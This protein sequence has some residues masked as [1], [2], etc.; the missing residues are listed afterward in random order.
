[1]SIGERNNV[2][3]YNL[4]LLGFGNVN[5]MLV[6]LLHERKHEL[7]EKHGI[8]CRVTGLATRRLGWIASPGGLDPTVLNEPGTPRWNLLPHL[9][10]PPG[11]VREW[12]R[13]ARADVLFEAT[14]L[15]TQTGQ[16]A[17]DHIRAALE[18]GAHAIT[19][20]KGPVVFAYEELRD[21][22][23][24][25]GRQFLFESTVMDGVPIFSTYLN[26][27]PLVHLK[28]FHGILNS[29][30]NLILS[31]MED[32]L[33]FQESLKR[34]QDLGIAETDASDDVEGWDAAVKVAA[35]V[36]VLMGVPLRLEEIE[37]TGIRGL[38]S[39]TVRAAR[40]EGKP[41]KLVCRAARNHAGVK[42]S[43]R[44]EQ[45]PL[46]NPMAHV[47]GTSSAV[48]FETDVFPGLAITE[49]HPGLEATAY[50]MLADFIRA[51]G[52]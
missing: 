12:L 26:H 36:R 4:C 34:A 44:P 32:G 22:A 38:T 49:N 50:G 46:S 15:N 51:V 2:Q 20:N 5:R 39:E 52:R 9:S 14:S 8:T 33:S 23:A 21:L 27:L 25:R 47:A 28:G 35:L 30:T 11:D 13:A 48:Y 10:P 6:K 1:V 40:E 19:A 16:P 37:R 41:Y 29:T 17:V 7:R 45:V 31:G 24:R 43:V 3:S 18:A 42:A